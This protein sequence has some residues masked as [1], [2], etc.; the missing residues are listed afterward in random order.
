LSSLPP[1][2]TIFRRGVS[3]PPKGASNAGRVLLVS[4]REQLARHAS[5]AAARAIDHGNAPKLLV[6]AEISRRENPR[7]SDPGHQTS[8]K[9]AIHHCIEF[10]FE[11]LRRGLFEL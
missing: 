6:A 10:F 4:I 5:T 8:M 11:L 1:R 9:I 2:K 7:K 3:S